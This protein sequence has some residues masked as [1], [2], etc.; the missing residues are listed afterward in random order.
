MDG[1]PELF[2]GLAEALLHIAV[3]APLLSTALLADQ[4]QVL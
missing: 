4:Q 3:V 1:A 2:K